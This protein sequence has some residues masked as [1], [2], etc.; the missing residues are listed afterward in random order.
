MGEISR[1]WDFVLWS[2]FALERFSS[3][4]SFGDSNKT[5]I[6]FG[7]DKQSNLDLKGNRYKPWADMSRTLSLF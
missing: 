2:M 4:Y 5:Q 1:S 6:P 7:N 3:R